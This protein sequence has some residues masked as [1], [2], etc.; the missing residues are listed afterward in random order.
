VLVFDI[1]EVAE[2]GTHKF[3]IDLKING[4]DFGTLSCT[5]KID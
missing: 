5:L 3:K 1:S 2:A 4:V